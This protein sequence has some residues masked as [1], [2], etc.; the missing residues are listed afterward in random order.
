MN[1]FHNFRVIAKDSQKLKI[2][3]DRIVEWCVENN[4]PLWII[5]WEQTPDKIYWGY[6]ITKEGVQTAM[7]NKIHNTH[8]NIIDFTSSPYS[9]TRELEIRVNPNKTFLRYFTKQ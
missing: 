6:K 1:K 5:S 8:A 3:V 9:I 4:Q 2:A 7:F